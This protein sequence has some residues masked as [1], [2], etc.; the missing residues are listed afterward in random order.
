MACAPLILGGQNMHPSR[1][2]MSSPTCAALGKALK[3]LELPL[4]YRESGKLQ[5]SSRP[6]FCVKKAIY[7]SLLSSDLW[8]LTLTW[9]LCSTTANE[10]PSSRLPDDLHVPSKQSHMKLST[11]DTNHPVSRW[12]SRNAI[13]SIV[14]L[15]S[16]HVPA[17]AQPSEIQRLAW[18][19]VPI[20]AV[21]GLVAAQ[22]EGF[23][24]LRRPTPPSSPCSTN[25]QLEDVVGE[26][27]DE[28]PHI[29]PPIFFSP[30]PG[31]FYQ[32]PGKQYRHR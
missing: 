25:L 22:D 28:Q 14:I 1:Q 7:T 32:S 10:I 23:P 9:K 12:H 30:G 29:N 19:M 2:G 16:H 21:A 6:A 27:H 24:V 26:T 5:R 8:I 13:F 20:T 4:P 11:A 3:G 17:C 31:N 15:Q 18:A